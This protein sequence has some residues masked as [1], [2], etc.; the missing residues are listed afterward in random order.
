MTK[1]CQ[2]III[3][4]GDN[5]ELNH[6]FNDLVN[7][8]YIFEKTFD[9]IQRLNIDEEKRVPT[10]FEVLRLINARNNSLRAKRKASLSDE[11]SALVFMAEASVRRFSEDG[12]FL[13]RKIE[14]QLMNINIEVKAP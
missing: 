9:E 10:L 13:S 4:G 2:L 12:C 14:T 5:G 8:E 7:V 3:H 6:Q 11:E 1:D